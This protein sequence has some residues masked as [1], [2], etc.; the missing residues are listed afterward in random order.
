[1]TSLA[2]TSTVLY[3]LPLLFSITDIEKNKWQLLKTT[4]WIDVKTMQPLPPP[5]FDEHKIDMNIGTRRYT[6]QSQERSRPEESISWLKAYDLIERSEV[7]NP[8]VVL[9]QNEMAI[10][11]VLDIEEIPDEVAFGLVFGAILV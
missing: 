11:D 7:I 8:D 2:R 9:K 10:K 3:G 1:L 6:I 4:E 5:P